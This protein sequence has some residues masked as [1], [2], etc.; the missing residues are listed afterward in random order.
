M[1][2]L[3]D[4][5]LQ[6]LATAVRGEFPQLTRRDAALPQVPKVA[7]AIIGA[8]RAGKTTFMWQQ[9]QAR[10]DA[11]RPRESLLL[12]ELEDDRLEGITT[13]DLDWVL[14]EYFRRYPKLRHET[15][16]TLCLD[17]IQVVPE[18]ERL[19]RRVLDTERVAL[20]LSGSSA[21]LL[22]REIATSLRG[23][24]LATTVHPFSFREVLR[25]AGA[26]PNVPWISLMA[27]E[28]SELDHHLRSYLQSGGFPAA[29]GLGS[30]DADML[31]SG[32]VDV[33]VLRDV[34]DRHGISNPEALR[35]L[36][37]QL[38]SIPGGTF[39]IKHFYAALRAEGLSSGK[40]VLHEF[41]AYLEDCYLIRTVTLHAQSAKRRMVNPRKVYPIDPGLIP[42]FAG[43]G[44]D[45]TRAAL[46]TSVLLELE[47]RGYE[48]GYFRTSEGEGID[49]LATARGRKK[50]LIEVTPHV[51]DDTLR[52]LQTA[53]REARPDACILITLD[54]AP[55]PKDIPDGIDWYSAA[56]W[57]LDDASLSRE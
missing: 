9:L 36:Q 43:P 12:L 10:L 17:E 55:A 28:R 4:V 50:L 49:F 15:E 26:E 30:R 18:W 22:S 14:E 27:G 56:H 25:H 29:Q 46:E 20:L 57:L 52:V 19:V 41:L 38:L 35:W 13:A 21:K 47:R 24:S 7:H 54:S 32:Y 6:R 11:G 31:L 40:D 51:T 2:Y 48:V 8:R 39:S 45:A 42:L 34:I 16:V 53:R 23:R 33:M 3:Q 1:T 44:I 37:R 5:L